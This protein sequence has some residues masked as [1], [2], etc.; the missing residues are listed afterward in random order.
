MSPH[1][2]GHAAM[3]VFAALV[4]GSFSLG[5][6]AAPYI[7]PMV[8]NAARFVIG[9]IV[10]WGLALTTGGVGRAVF[11]AP[12][13]YFVLAGL[14]AIYFVTMF[15]GLKTAE[16][17]SMAAVFTLNPALTA[18]FGYILLRQVTT[19]RMAIAIVI[20]GVGALWVIFDADLSALVR[21]EVGR[22]EAVYFWGCIAHALYSPVLRKLSRGEGAFAFNAGVLSAGAVILIVLSGPK[23]VQTDWAALPGIVWVTILYV[24]LLA[25]AVTF[26]CLRYATLRLPSA[27]VMAYTYI[28]PSWVI[29]WE[30]ALG[31]GVPPALILPGVALTA[32]SLLMLLKDEERVAVA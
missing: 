19:P 25:T 5:R 4:A 27:K 17:V 7:D 13:R 3:M 18:V 26:M 29:L 22:G 28:V 30:V 1:L 14:F 20:G 21:F 2:K 6:M 16:P 11:D 10:L 31:H 24:A 8:L 23:L 32:L 12:W 15:E 9:A